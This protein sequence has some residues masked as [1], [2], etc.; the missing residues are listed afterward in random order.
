MSLIFGSPE[1]CISPYSPFF[2]HLGDE[3]SSAKSKQVSAFERAMGH[4]DCPIFRAH[5]ATAEDG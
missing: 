2:Q 3:P 1:R 4:I 5:H